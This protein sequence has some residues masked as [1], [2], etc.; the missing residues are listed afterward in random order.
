[1]KLCIDPGHGFSNARPGRYD[2][3]A[4]SSGICEADIVLSW[5]LTLKWVCSQRKIATFLTRDDDRDADPVGSRDDRAE[6][7]GCTHFLSLHCNSTDDSRVRGVEAFYR[8]HQ[9]RDWAE[10]ALFAAVQAMESTNRGL[11]TEGSSQHS[12]LA[13]F[14]FDGPCTLVELGFITNSKDRSKLLSRDARLTFANSFL[15]RIR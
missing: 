2:S 4:C 3:G 1:M 5:A 13:V 14:E 12:R 9:D 15:D 11:K 10:K 8:S 7:A 6:V